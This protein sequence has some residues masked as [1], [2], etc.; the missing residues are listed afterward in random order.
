MRKFAIV[1]VCSVLVVAC[2]KQGAAGTSDPAVAAR[3]PEESFNE[4]QRKEFDRWAQGIQTRNSVADIDRLKDSLKRWD[5]LFMNPASPEMKPV[6][7]ALKERAKERLAELEKEAA[8][9]PR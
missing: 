9:R 5:E 4:E 1:A 3:R 6:F 2:D 8:T 7:A